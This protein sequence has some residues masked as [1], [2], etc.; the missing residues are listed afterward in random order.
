MRHS[1]DNDRADSS[2]LYKDDDGDV[3][4]EGDQ[5]SDMR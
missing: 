1:H 3:R 4:M 5:D 2:P